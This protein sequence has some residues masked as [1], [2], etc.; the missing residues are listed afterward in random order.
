LFLLPLLATKIL[1]G[2]RLQERAQELPHLHPDVPCDASARARTP[3]GIMN[4]PHKS[5]WAFEGLEDLAKLYLRGRSGQ[6]DPAAR[7]AND[8]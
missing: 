2:L 6:T 5:N 4:T 3:L 8:S 7:P 1:Q